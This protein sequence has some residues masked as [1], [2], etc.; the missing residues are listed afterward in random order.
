MFNLK[1]IPL[2]IMM[3]LQYM[4][5]GLWFIKLGP[6]LAHLGFSSGETGAIFGVF[7]L[8]SLLS[9][10]IG[11]QIADRLMPSQIFLGIVHLAGGAILIYM[12]KVQGFTQLWW[13]MLIYSL[14]YA[15]T[16]ALTNA[17]CFHHLDNKEK[18][19]GVI[20]ACGTVG[21]IAAGFLLTYWWTSV[22]PFNADKFASLTDPVQKAQYIS[23]ESMLYTLSG[24][25]SLIMGFFCFALPNTP[26]S[27]EA[28][29]PFAFIEALKLLKD[30]NFAVFLG[31]SIVVST[32][33]M[34]YYM[35]TPG[36]LE[37]MLSSNLVPRTTTLAQGG[38]LVTL[39]LV[40]PFVLSRLGIRKTIAIG[41][42]AWPLR[43]AIFAI[44]H[45]T[46][47]IMAAL[48][49]HGICYVFFFIVGQIYVDTIA[50]ANI[51]ASAQSLYFQAVFGL[52]LFLGSG[53]VGWVQGLFTTETTV[54]DAVTK[55]SSVN[56][57]VDYTGLFMVPCV[58]TILCAIVF[59][60]FF[61]EP[62]R[63]TAESSN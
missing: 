46:W 55:V 42:I 11:G 63:S 31:L 59:F 6:Y 4:I 13:M 47:L 44:G 7:F 14:L 28:K 20:R 49:L 25:V 17:I 2:S 15:P 29:N 45:P 50:P 12:A 1:M 32:E 38:E 18:Q 39:I 9:P 10:F 33:L 56:L 54:V 19:F 51:R 57:V 40:L 5:W 3:F 21:W 23:T 34:F 61:R 37:T 16:L 8:A 26:P 43:Y 22:Q 60:V 27:K 48:P 24:V 58:L 41:I 62:E 30:P 52:G 53:L 36:F 35:P